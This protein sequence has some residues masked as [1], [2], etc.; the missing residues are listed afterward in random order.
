MMRVFTEDELNDIAV[1]LQHTPHKSL[2]H[3]EQEIRV[4]ELAAQ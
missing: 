3:L 1:M 4:S 2:R